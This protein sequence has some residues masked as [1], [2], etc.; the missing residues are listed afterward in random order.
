MVVSFAILT[1][2][3]NDP[4]KND[5]SLQDDNNQIRNDM[6]TNVYFDRVAELGFD[7]KLMEDNGELVIVE[8]DIAF[9]KTDLGI[10]SKLGKTMQRK[11][12]SLIS[13][14]NTNNIRLMVHSSMS[15]W[16]SVIS[17]AV[18]AWNTSPYSTIHIDIVTSSPE[19]TIYSDSATACPSGFQNLASNTCG[20]GAYSWNDNVGTTISINL[21]APYFP[22]DAQKIY[23]ITQEIGHTL[24]LAHTNETDGDFIGT[25]LWTDNNSL[26]LGG[27]CGSS[28]TLSSY[29][30]KALSCLYPLPWGSSFV[31]YWNPT[32]CDH[33]YTAGISE[34]GY[35]A[36]GYTFESI[37]G[38]T[39]LTPYSYST[40]PLYRFYHSGI[41]DHFYTTDYN[42]GINA[43]YTYEGVVGY[44]STSSHTNYVPLYQHWNAN[45][46]DHFYTTNPTEGGGDWVYE[47][48]ACYL[49]KAF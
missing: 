17:S 14:S 42:E 10:G 26:M 6:Q 9:K 18:S 28:K 35:G 24:G 37:E 34:I 16:N 2:C 22:T 32:D 25:T 8:G 15:G 46:G 11:V 4:V 30:K 21:D 45:G 43:G 47:K 5:S 33:F 3:S 40:T 49:F 48:I 29:D 12:S 27:D 19:L 38:V 13:T 44:V 1:G 20:L 41:T 31:R 23:F 7:T 36:Y 39:F